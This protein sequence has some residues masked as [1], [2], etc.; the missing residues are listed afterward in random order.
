MVFHI[1]LK[2]RNELFAG[3]GV[4]L[5]M[6]A[7]VF[8]IGILCGV[9]LGVARHRWSR[10]VGIPGTVLSVVFSSI[11]VIVLLFWLHYPLQYML[12]IVVDPFNTS[13]FALSLIMTV[14]VSDVITNALNTF[15]QELLKSAEVCGITYRTSILRIQ[16]PII[17]RQVLPSILFAMIVV[18]QATLFTSLISV[19]EIF[20]V[21]QQINAD[22][23]R[24]VEIYTALAVFFLAICA[25]LNALA[26]W[27]KAKYKW[28]DRDH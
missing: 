6:C 28:S 13:V 5:F 24:P 25:S 16:L 1:L 26:F 17:V 7:L 18:L 20:R 19:Q 14:L 3:I 11:P 4:T 23:Y 27:I 15:P 10:L 21:A 12:N 8:P 22:I 9:L 2:Y